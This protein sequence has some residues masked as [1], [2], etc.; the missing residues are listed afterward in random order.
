MAR[1]VLCADLHIRSNKPKHRKDDYFE[2][3]VVKLQQIIDLA[4]KRKANILCA[5]DI[6]DHTKVGHKVVN[7]IIDVL[8]SFNHKFYV[9]YGQHDSTYHS[10]NLEN[11]PLYTLLDKKNVILLNSKKPK[12]IN[13]FYVYGCSWE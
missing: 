2:S 1:F 11:S 4:N 9:V 10:K 5:G 8:N 7:K 13:G 12:K 6:F 3:V